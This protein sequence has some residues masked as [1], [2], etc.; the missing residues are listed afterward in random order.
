MPRRAR[1]DTPGALHHIIIRSIER[2][3]IFR[4]TA[5]REDFLKR[6]G[7][8]LAVRKLM[9][10]CADVARTLRI[11]PAAVSRATSRGVAITNMKQLQDKLLISTSKE[12]GK[13]S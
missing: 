11:S 6:L 8:I 13:I 2:Q 1:I 12:Q 10:S 5:D 3:A 7:D 4:N 9:I